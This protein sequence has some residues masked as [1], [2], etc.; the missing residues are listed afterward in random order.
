MKSYRY[1]LEGLDCA[2]CAKKVEDA[3]SKTEGYKNV[4]VNF[5]TLKLTFDTN[6]DF[7]LAKKEITQIVQRLEPEVKVLEEGEKNQEE[8]RS[9]FDIF[10]IIIGLIIF[11]A[12]LL[13]KFNEIVN[14]IITISAFVIL[15]YKTAKKGIKQ[16]IK[17]KV[18]D[19][20][21]LIVISAIGA[22]V[23][24]KT[25]EGLMVIVLYEIG[26]IL[27]ARAVNK[28]RKSISDLMNIKPEY[29]NLKQGDKQKTVNPEDIKI[30][31]IIIVKTGER[32]PLDGEVIKGNA[33]VDNSALTGESKL[34]HVQG[35]SKVL[36]GS[37]NVNGLIE[38]K[39]EKTYENSTVSQ[40][41]NLVE[42]ATDKKAKTETFVSKAAKIYTPI[43]IG[44][45]LVVAIF[46]PIIIKSITYK[47]GIYK[48]LIF[49]VISC[50]C[51]IAISVPLSYFSGIGKASKRGILIKG[52][53]YLDGIKDIKEIIFDKT[54]TITTG[55]FG[56]TEINS[57]D[58][59]NNQKDI[60]EFFAKGEK[61]SNHP[62][63]K[64]ILERYDQEVDTG[65]VQNFQEISGKGLQYEL[66]NHLVK[67]G[68]AN[69][70]NAKEEN[71]VGTVLYLNI[72]G[73][74]IGSIVLLDEIKLST[75]ETMTKLKKLGIIT[76]MF[77]GDK[78][79]IAEKIANEIQIEE[80]KFEMLPQDKYNEL[81]KII[82]QRNE[83]KKVAFIGD[84]INDSPVLARADIGISMG[85]IGASSAIEASDVVIMTDELDKIIEG[86][87]ISKK[88]N[89]II[90]QNLIFSIGIKILTLILSLFGITDMWQAVFADV[91][92]TLITILN[93]LRILK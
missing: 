56:V 86:I 89:L 12:T 2:A 67:I 30:G 31:D 81:D 74:V 36:S 70:T 4:I 17:N 58:K 32:I 42:N 51:S 6:K 55:R 23:I 79:E 63:A 19:E 44:L 87:E 14:N 46:M 50:P 18:L 26:K 11:G 73:D 91:G 37:I 68:N 27:E 16:L 10:R 54:G 78:K 48:A 66:E 47:E 85:G 8:E 38:I 93:T 24:G 77:T 92:V 72:D 90:K 57:Y 13:F 82:N 34:V 88:T 43:V 59:K 35:K 20:N 7:K 60:L 65:D 40:I 76:K 71:I 64:S 49:L 22:Y 39:V 53:D 15:L 29:A 33:E 9:K 83:S 25:S 28:T 75:K 62:I 21:F 41:L 45:A 52:S 3:I 80:V 84:G 5:S 69:F 61:F 1:I